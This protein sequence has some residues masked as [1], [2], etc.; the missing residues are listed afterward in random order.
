MVW[1][2]TA[3]FHLREDEGGSQ[4]PKVEPSAFSAAVLG[5]L[6]EKALAR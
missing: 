4:T 5:D 2:I 6:C 3:E 1:L